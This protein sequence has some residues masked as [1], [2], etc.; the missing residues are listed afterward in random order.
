MRYLIS[1][2]ITLL[3]VWVTTLGSLNFMVDLGTNVGY[4]VERMILGKGEEGD[5]NTLDEWLAERHRRLQK[6]GR[7]LGWVQPAVWLAPPGF[8]S[9]AAGLVEDAQQLR[10][11]TLELVAEVERLHS[12]Y[13][14][15]APLIGEP[16]FIDGEGLPERELLLQRKSLE[17]VS[18]LDRI[19]GLAQ[20]WRKLR[21]RMEAIGERGERMAQRAE[22]EKAYWVP[23]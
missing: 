2:L 1:V 19:V 10:Q 3:V 4:G 15:F 16:L 5:I 14:A 12:Q 9:D 11:D 23:Y 7:H 8:R 18:Q 13:D 20:R 6:A 22:A 21:G 17:L